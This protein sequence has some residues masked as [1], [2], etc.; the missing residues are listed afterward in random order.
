MN[1][2]I[3]D[4][5]GDIGKTLA[6]LRKAAKKKQAD[7]AESLN[8]AQ[9]HVSRIEKGKLIPTNEEI[10]GYLSA[11]D[12]DEARD[13]LAFLKP[14]EILK[15]PSFRNPQR[16]ELWKAETSLRELNQLI[17]NDAPDLLKAQA[18]MYDKRVRE[19]AEYLT[20]L[21]HSIAYVGSVGVGKTTAVCKLTGLIMPQ[22]KNFL[23]QS[24]LAVGSGRTT[25]CEVCIRPGAKFGIRV[26]LKSKDEIHKLVE[27]F[28]AA[29]R[30]IDKGN[31]ENQLEVV[32]EE[33][34]RLLLNMAG[35]Q[36]ESLAELIK[37]CD[38]ADTLPLK[39]LE[40]LKLPE[41]TREEIEYDKTSNQ[42]G[43]EWL[44]E[45]F[46]LINY[47]RHKEFSVPQRIDV[48]VPDNVFQFSD[49]ELEIIDTQGIDKT[50]IRRDLLGYLNDQRTLTVLCSRFK[51]APDRE[52]YDLLEN[53]IK[54]GAKKTLKERV[55]ILALPQND[56]ADNMM[57][58]AGDP[59]NSTDEAYNLK[60]E[61]VQTKLQPLLQSIEGIDI[62]IIFFNAKSEEDNPA[63]IANELI[64]K[65]DN[66]RDSYVKQLSSTVE[67]INV[68][69]KNQKEQNARDAYK[70]VSE[71]L[72]IFLKDYRNK[73]LPLWN[74]YTSLIEQMEKT[75]A[76]TIRATMRRNGTWHKF[77]VYLHLGNKARSN[78]WS[79]TRPAFY[80]LKELVKNMNHKPK[81]EPAYNFL[82]EILA[83]WEVWHEEFLKYAE[84][85]GE[86][87]FRPT[88]VKSYIWAECA[89]LE[90]AGFREQ[91]IWKLRPWFKNPEQQHLHNFLKNRIEEA[92]Q[93]KVLAQLEKLT[94]KGTEGD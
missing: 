73:P 86:Q 72:K 75:P 60:R 66:L 61:E 13:Y 91:V 7:I 58:Y 21:K 12:T 1:I 53:L 76:S 62:P 10:E 83:N 5:S 19:E 51:D 2:S 45:T 56:E 17:S 37:Q 49:Y 82:S 33:M 81:L 47:G 11:I 59:V 18:Q 16:D 42:T 71:S 20:S 27:D 90:G 67:A 94:D 14:W 32:S 40:L 15:R 89:A 26:K 36:P 23:R 78:A 63:K 25:V 79:A 44:K 41:R 22:E 55:L 43:I 57:N 46:K 6:E 28:C 3:Y 88:L 24:I 54:N 92:W 30:N 29:K 80:G 64:K 52:I 34:Q 77:D 69:I 31:Q 8:V 84:Q 4:V 74:V 48:I 65:L 38:N 39:F 85:I 93:E 35:L 9:S 50:A 68:L 87:I 70:E